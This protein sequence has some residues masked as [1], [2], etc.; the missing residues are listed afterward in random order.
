MCVCHCLGSFEMIKFLFFRLLPFGVK[1]M[2]LERNRRQFSVWHSR[3]I[4]RRNLPAHSGTH[5]LASLEQMH[6][7]NSGNIGYNTFSPSVKWMRQILIPFHFLKP[8]HFIPFILDI[9][10]HR[11]D[12]ASVYFSSAYLSLF[13]ISLAYIL[14]LF[15]LFPKLDKV[16]SICNMFLT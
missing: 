4:N 11:T 9:I 10:A 15:T 14:L 5:L 1:K 3:S 16:P 6:Q 13:I 8:P 7:L 2:L 12:I